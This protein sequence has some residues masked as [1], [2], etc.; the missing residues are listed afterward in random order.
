MAE[1]IA[2]Y[3]PRLVEDL[4]TLQVGLGRLP[5]EMLRHLRNRHDLSVH[6][7]VLTDSVADLVEAGV[8]TGPV[9]GSWAMGTSRLYDL[10]AEDDRFS[11]HPVDHVCDPAVIAQHERMVSVTQ[12]FTVD[13]SGQVCTERLDGR[14]YGGESTAPDFHRGALAAARGVPVVCLSSRTPAGEPALRLALGPDEPVALARTDVRW[15]VTE[16]ARRTCSGRRWPSGPWPWSRSP[17][18]GRPGDAA[19]ASPRGRGGRRGPGAP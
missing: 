7:D 3:V 9:V 8:V 11:L 18:P 14:L 2:R 17:T 19:R 16:Y 5:V 1:Q 4:A 13:L 10:L 12:A 6:S 15:V